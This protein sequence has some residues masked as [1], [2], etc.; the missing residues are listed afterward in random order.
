MPGGGTGQVSPWPGFPA[1]TPCCVGA[2]HACTP[3]CLTAR[4]RGCV[5]CSTCW[6]QP[7]RSRSPLCLAHAP[8]SS[9]RSTI[10]VVARLCTPLQP[11]PGLRCLQCGRRQFG[12]AVGGG[13]WAHADGPSGAPSTAAAAGKCAG[14]QAPEGAK[15]WVAPLH[16]CLPV[17]RDGVGGRRVVTEGTSGWRLGW[18]ARGKIQMPTLTA[19]L[20]VLCRHAG[21]RQQLGGPGAAVG[22]LGPGEGLPQGDEGPEPAPAEAG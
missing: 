9:S 2:W 16:A 3:C 22:Q 1:C 21:A 8:P 10:H 6:H 19:V 4:Q 18:R 12:G 5:R 11:R 20:G 13:G 14:R 7:G 15:E 17:Q